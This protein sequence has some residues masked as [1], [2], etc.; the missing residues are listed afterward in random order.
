VVIKNIQK[1]GELNAAI[2]EFQEALRLN[3]NAKD[4]MNNLGLALA[5]KRLQDENK[6]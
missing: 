6:N 4:A 5:R 3:Q 1:K 2:Q